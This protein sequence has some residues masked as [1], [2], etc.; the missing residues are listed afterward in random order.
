MIEQCGAALWPMPTVIA[1]EVADGRG[2]VADLGA[3]SLELAAGFPAG[4]RSC[5]GLDAPLACSSRNPHSSPLASPASRIGLGC[6]FQTQTQ[7]QTKHRTPAPH[8]CA[9][10][11]PTPGTGDGSP[12]PHTSPPQTSSG[13]STGSWPARAA[14][15][16]GAGPCRGPDTT[17]MASNPPAG[18]PSQRSR[19][20]PP[21]RSIS[22]PGTAGC[23]CPAAAR[24][25]SL[26]RCLLTFTPRSAPPPAAFVAC[27]RGIAAALQ[28][29]LL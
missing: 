12:P 2:L 4:C 10:M 14:R 19:G 8:P 11:P 29:W 28:L 18:P 1:A 5:T 27:H 13:R 17:G 21:S 9:H 23:G 22:G 24:L 3:V 15:P 26:V 20:S 25:G 7:T 6:R 16:Q